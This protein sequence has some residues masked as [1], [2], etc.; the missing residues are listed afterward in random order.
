M[1]TKVR[2]QAMKFLLWAIFAFLILDALAKFKILN[3]SSAVNPYFFPTVA[4]LFI[5]LD[6][7]VISLKKGL[8][9]TKLSGLHWFLVA[10][11]SI[12]LLGVLLSVVKISLGDSFTSIFG[13]ANLVLSIAVL[14]SIF[15]D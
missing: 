15:T 4:G 7:G 1:N 3:L 10:F 8:Q 11:A 9:R 12:V 5:L 14:V 13:L 6:V 2:P